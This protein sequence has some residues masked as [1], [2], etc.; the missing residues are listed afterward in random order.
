MDNPW[1]VLLCRVVSS[2]GLTI[3][4]WT[5]C[6]IT[7]MI[8]FSHSIGKKIKHRY[9]S[10]TRV[11]HQFQSLERQVYADY[12]TSVSFSLCQRSCLIW[13]IMTNTV[14]NTYVV[15]LSSASIFDRDYHS[16]YQNFE[17]TAIWYEVKRDIQNCLDSIEVLYLLSLQN[18][19]VTVCLI[20]S[21][22]TRTQCFCPN[23][24]AFR[25]TMNFAQLY[26][27]VVFIRIHQM[28]ALLINL[29][30]GWMMSSLHDWMIAA[31][32]ELVI[33]LYFK[34]I[35]LIIHIPSFDVAE[36]RRYGT[37]LNSAVKNG[38]LTM[39]VYFVKWNRM[40]VG[41]EWELFF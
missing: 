13:R 35:V 11:R 23:S 36:T 38:K 24:I 25:K 32:L 37:L 10:F 4:Q 34:S 2:S 14:T 39:N 5:R 28:Q 40:E 8:T 15:I 7:G 18:C 33:M 1:S 30:G 21:T 26:L 20:F 29:E 17:F 22:R 16:R 12:W 41:M 3:W 27:L 19:S 6:L 31:P 9:Q